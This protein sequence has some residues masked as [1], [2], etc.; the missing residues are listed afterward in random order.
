LFEWHLSAPVIE[1]KK[2]SPD[3]KGWGKRQGNTLRLTH[4]PKCPSARD[5]SFAA[6]VFWLERLHFVSPSQDKSFGFLFRKSLGF[7]LSDLDSTSDE[8]KLG[9]YSG[10]SAWDLHP[11]SRTILRPSH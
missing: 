1:N 8:T 9:S 3:G 4:Q 7:I 10:G 5:Y 2:P 11:S 6:Q